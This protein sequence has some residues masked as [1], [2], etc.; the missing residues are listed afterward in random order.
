MKEFLWDWRFIIAIVIALAI[1]SIFEWG[2]VKEWVLQGI[3]MAKKL[4]K[5]AVLSSGQ[6]QEDWVVMRVWPCLPAPVRLVLSE[7]L[8]RKLIRYM[9]GKAK[10]LLDDGEINGSIS[11]GG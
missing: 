3:A 8:F 1:Y 9:Y 6:E 5:D 11:Q 2:K 10:D 7:A 4:A